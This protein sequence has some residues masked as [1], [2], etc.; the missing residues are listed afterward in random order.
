[1]LKRHIKA[2]RMMRKLSLSEFGNLLYVSKT[3]LHLIETGKRLPSVKLLCKMAVIFD[4]NP[5]WL[6]SLKENAKRT[7]CGSFYT[8]EA[9]LL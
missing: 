8:R 7:P 1:M 6:I 5:N 3:H 9:S 4:C 2:L